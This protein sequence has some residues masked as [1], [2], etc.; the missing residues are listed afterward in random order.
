MALTDNCDLY[1]EI[2]KDGINHVAK[3]IMQQR[4][5]LFNYCTA[6]VA[7]NP[8]LLCKPIKVAQDVDN[9]RNPHITVED[10]LPVF[11]TNGI[12]GLNFCFQITE[13]EIDFHPGKVFTL[14]PELSPPLGAQKFAI[15]AQVC[16][17]IGCPSEKNDIPIPPSPDYSEKVEHR[18]KIEYPQFVP[19]TEKL[20]CFCLDLFVVGHI[21][22]NG[23][24]GD[25]RL[26]GKVDGLE[27]VDIEPNGLENSFEC[28]LNLLFKTVI[29]PRV[30][31]A[32]PTMVFDILNL[33][34]I[35][36]SASTT[37]SNNPAIED[38]KLKVFI[39]LGV[40]P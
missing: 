34:T 32:I 3:N 9:F 11:G 13:L 18:H 31:I 16:G 19:S 36:L 22:M 5:S 10:P 21:E 2:H 7:A 30:S 35:T 39:D 26:L 40:S 28:Y 23:P 29:L 20:E 37:V 14:P 8:Y 15:H 33:A 1:G 17:G 25:Q 12:I 24:V 38:D 27:I 4:P 6:F